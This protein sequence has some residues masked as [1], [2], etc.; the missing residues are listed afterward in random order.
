M[1]V[2]ITGAQ[3]QLGYHLKQAFDTDNLFLGDTANFDVTNRETVLKQTQ[4]FRPDLIIHAAAYTNVDGA[5]TNRE[6]CR[7]VNVEGT[8]HVA[9]AARAVEAKLIHISTDYVFSGDKSSPY[10]ETDQPGPISYY[11]K[12]K[13]E[14]EQVVVTTAPKHFICRTAWLYGGPKP[15]PDFDFT[16]PGLPKNFIYTMLRLGKE[17]SE[18][19]VVNDQIGAPTYAADIAQTLKLLADTMQYGIY[20]LTNSGQTSWAGVAKAIFQQSRYNTT[21]KEVTSA[22]WATINPQAT[23]RPANSVLAH[24]HL[25]DLGLPDLRSWQT[26][27]TDFLSALV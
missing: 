6:V 27:L 13:Y 18:I 8:K 19:A 26:A 3:G 21:V 5:E 14:A 1:N 4:Q 17:K 12:T 22:Q 7:A 2:L 11:G 16:Q 24:Q 15:T 9:E 23:H 10:L 20:H 25:L